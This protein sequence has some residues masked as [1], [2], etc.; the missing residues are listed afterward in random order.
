MSRQLRL[1]LERREGFRAQD[2]IASGANAVA[3]AAL[4]AWPHW[5][6]GCLALVGPA[7]SG[8]SHLAHT[9]AARVGAQVLTAA[10]AV[11]LRALEGGP[12]VLEDADR[13]AHD[14]DLFHL[15]N[16]AAVEGGGLL[17]TARTPPSVWPAALPDLR[18]RLNA[19][20][21]AELAEPD[22]AILGAVFEKFFR[23]RNIKPADDLI[24][25]LL[26]RIERSVPRALEIVT[27]LD[28]ASDADGRAV[29]KALA[30]QI[31]DSEAPSLDLFE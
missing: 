10:A 25:Y 1:K 8:K 4:A 29:S 6:G 12:V 27:R 24:P 5:H 30:R 31:L 20:R 21:V 22:D 13:G 23:E 9:W 26:N 14:E 15:I 19:M 18:S 16:M 7:G 28:E 11:D 17:L 2:F 3:L